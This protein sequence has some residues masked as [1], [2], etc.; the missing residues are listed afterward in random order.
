M[1]IRS[2]NNSTIFPLKWI[3]NFN[4]T[5]IFKDIKD[6]SFFIKEEIKNET[7]GKE[8]REY[9]KMVEW[10]DQLEK[11]IEK[12]HK[13][14]TLTI[15]S[16]EYKL[17]IKF[18]DPK[19]VVVAL[20]TRTIKNLFLEMKQDFFFKSK[21]PSLFNNTKL[22]RIINLNE[23]A[24]GLATLGDQVLGLVVVQ[25]AW[26]KGLYKKEKITDEKKNL[27]NNSN[28]AKIYDN[29]NLDENEVSIESK[30]QITSQENLIHKKATFLEAIIWV[31]YL[32]NGLEKVINLLNKFIA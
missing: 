28:L 24:E 18:Q 10:N 32:E 17:N 25:K 9:K 16:I 12:L 5:S 11:L 22:D 7:F 23:L 3:D 13:I 27:V 19:K 15:P 6:I 26:E 30:N 8:R 31:Y 1:R 21:Y 14:E 2:K 4:L 20:F 29:L